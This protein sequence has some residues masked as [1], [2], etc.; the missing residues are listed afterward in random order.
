MRCIPLYW[1]TKDH[2]QIV[3]IHAELKRLSGLMHDA[4][5]VADTNFVLQVEEK[6]SH[7]CHHSEKLA[8][9]FELI[10]I[11]PSTP[12]GIVKNLN[13]RVCRDCQTS[14]KFISKIVGRGI[15]VR[16]AKHFHHIENGICSCMGYW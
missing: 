1:T 7:L 12:L 16:D 11:V 3:E 9:A 5:Y 2:H 8:I 6:V 10:D 14:A 4:G 13:L 15:M